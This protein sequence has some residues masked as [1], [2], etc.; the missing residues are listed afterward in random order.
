MLTLVL[1]RAAAVGVMGTVVGGVFGPAVWGPLGTIVRGLPAW[2]TGVVLRYAALFVGVAIAGA[3]VPAW[4]AARAQ[5][6]RLLASG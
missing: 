6:A 2:D 5:P 4:R 3:L 1:L